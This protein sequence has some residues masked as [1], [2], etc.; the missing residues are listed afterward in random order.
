MKKGLTISAIVMVM[1]ILL[2]NYPIVAIVDNNTVNVPLSFFY[3]YGVW[4][5]LIVI[6]FAFNKKSVK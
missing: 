2:F 5:I 4:G 1:A 6:Y 3:F